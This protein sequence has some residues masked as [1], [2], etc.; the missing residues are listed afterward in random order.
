MPM[1]KYLRVS[2]VVD[3]LHLNRDVELDTVV[4]FVTRAVDDL[5]VSARSDRWIITMRERERHALV[6]D[7]LILS[8]T[9]QLTVLDNDAFLSQYEW[10]SE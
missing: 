6:G 8:R 2:A 5:G 10:V 9:N 3:A 1:A 4:D 7:W